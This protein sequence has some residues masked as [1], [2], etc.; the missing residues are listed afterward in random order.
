MATAVRQAV[1]AAACAER[2]SDAL[3]GSA[4]LNPRASRTVNDNDIGC[5]IIYWIWLQSYLNAIER[6]TRWNAVSAGSRGGGARPRYDKY[7]HR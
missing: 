3:D 7:V 2:R 4:R 1:Y 6:A 5:L